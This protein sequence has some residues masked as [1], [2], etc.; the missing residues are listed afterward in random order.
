MIAKLTALMCVVAFLFSCSQNV[1][2]DTFSFVTAEGESVSVEVPEGAD[3]PELPPGARPSDGKEKGGAKE[4]AQKD[5]K[6]SKEPPKPKVVRRQETLN[7]QSDPEELRATVGEDGKVAFAFRNQ[8]WVDLVQWLAEISNQPLDW[9]ELPGDR[10]NLRSPGR[11]TVAQTRDLFNRYLLARGYTLLEIDGG[12]TVAKTETINPAIVP[13]VSPETLAD[14]APYTFVRTSM[15]VGW[16]SAEKLSEEL[17]PMISSNGRLTALTTTNRIEAMDAAVNLRQV[18]SLLDQ[19]RSTASR[20]S[21]APEFQL[22]YLSAEEAKK[23]LEQFLGIKEN[24][25]GGMTPEQMQQMM[26]MQQQNGGA[27]PQ[28]KKKEI[29][30]VANVRQNSILINAT[31]DRVAIAHEFLK[32]VD[33]PGEGMKNLMDVKSRVQVF[34]LDSLD[35]KKLI[36]IVNEMNVLEP[37]T[38][39]RIDKENK[40]LIVSGSVADRYVIGSLIERLDGSARQFEVMPLRRLDPI[41]VAESITFLMGQKKEK[42]KNTRRRYYYYYNDDE[43]EDEQGDEFRVAA[44]TRLKQILLWANER[45]LEQVQSLLIKLGELPP[46]GGSRQ[47][48]RILD[49]SPAPET[50]EY[51]KRLQKQW[52]Q[53]APNPLLL[54]D[55][56]AFSDPNERPNEMG[57]GT[58]SDDEEENSGTSENKAPENEPDQDLPAA[59]DD[60]IAVSNIP[61]AILVAHNDTEDSSDEPSSPPPVIRSRKDFDKQFGTGR[62]PSKSVRERSKEV[63]P[64]RIEL[65]MQGNLVLVSE[66]TAALDRLEN[67]ML[68]MKPPKRPYVVFH[69]EHASCS[70]MKLNLEDYF[71]DL[72]KESGSDANNFFSW[73]WGMDSGDDEKKPSGLG[74]G[75]KMRFVSDLDTNTLVVSGATPEQ[76]RTIDELIELWDVPEPVNKRKTRFTKLVVI[77]YGKAEK[78]AETVKEAYRDLLSSNDKTFSGGGG[79]QEGGDNSEKVSKSRAGN[80]SGLEDSGSGR[81]GGGADFRFKGKLSIGVDSL[82]N[83]LLVSAE[84]EP[85]LDLVSDMIG[86][87]DQAA[88]PQ[89]DVQIVQLSGSMSGDSLRSAL[90]ALGTSG[91]K[92]GPTDNRGEIPKGERE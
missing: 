32:R 76:L 15:D 48:V 31:P 63:H 91:K 83:T 73:Y 60:S 55:V 21:L 30:I 54:P 53:L 38:R 45:E 29:S 6:K 34:R 72:E 16:L 26:Q 71:R 43:E 11:Y 27:R 36:E 87:L 64:I 24:P 58:A 52:S 9:L 39:V 41:E 70:W 7:D 14:L 10:V 47:T 51:L 42:E 67:L 56:E 88:R 84:G 61:K 79:G 5:K 68:Q 85:L 23:L 18:V 40:A 75:N 78:I 2:A 62:A 33:V 69:I 25:N 22:R 20:E 59:G 12:I 28:Q 35:P 89:G 80:G 81:D 74:K 65:D 86:Q 82:G 57:D 37:S 77:E 50:L 4:A 3:P 66:D 17:K 8:P 19:E 49:A 13:R 92:A 90:E 46:P 1:L 44:N